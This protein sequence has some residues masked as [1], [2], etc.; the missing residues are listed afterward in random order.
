MRAD[1]VALGRGHRAHDG[2]DLADLAVVDRPAACFISLDMP[3][4]SA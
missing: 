3:G 2:L 1:V 4:M